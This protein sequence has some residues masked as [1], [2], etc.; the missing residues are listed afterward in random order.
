M[1]VT[2]TNAAAPLFEADWV[3]QGTHISS[4]GSDAPGKQELPVELL[5]R[6][7]LFCD[8]SDQSR[9]I[10]EF[11]HVPQ[12]VLTEIGRVLTGT[13]QGRSTGDSVTV[14]DSSGISLQ[15]LFVASAV[16]DQVA[17]DSQ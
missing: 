1:I 11:Q 9:R 4:M 13:A 2:A 17:A 10:G 16:I 5:L 3:Q 6:A 15:D 7:E 8:L 14:F 12:A